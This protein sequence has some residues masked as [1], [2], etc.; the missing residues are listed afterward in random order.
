MCARRDCGSIGLSVSQSVNQL[1]SQSASQSAL[2]SRRM[3]AVHS[4]MSIIR[5]VYIL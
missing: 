3:H 4:L 2:S 5:I 1:V